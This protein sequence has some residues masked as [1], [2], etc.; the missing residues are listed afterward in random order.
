GP[1]PAFY[2]GRNLSRE[3]A[4]GVMAGHIIEKHRP[5]L[6]MVH[7]NQTDYSQHALGRDDLDN[8]LAIAAVDGAITRMVEAATRAGTLERTAFII[9][10]D[11]GFVDVH[12]RVR[13]NVWLVE[14]GLVENRPD[15]GAWR[16]VFHEGNGSTFLRLKDPSDRAAVDRVRALLAALPAEVRAL[17]RVVERAELDRLG[18]DPDS[19]L[20]LAAVQGV[21]FNA[22]LSGEAVAAGGSGGTH[23]YF[24]EFAQ[25]H[26]GFVAWG[27]GVAEGRV[28]TMMELVDI[29]PTAAALLALEFRA[30]DGAA[31]T[32]VMKPQAQAGPGR[33][34]ARH[35]PQPE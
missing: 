3:D 35:A 7:L 21:A 30:P 2:W 24:P 32:E 1:F 33:D 10:G 18:A 15:R 6:L 22:A 13:P 26:T 34:D 9:T 8:G 28:I 25:I 5:A 27:S 16:A 17:F 23:G 12:T 14:A 4:V 31:R 11:H 20:A 29:A 19:P